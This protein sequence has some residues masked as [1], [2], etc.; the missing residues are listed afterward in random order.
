[1]HGIVPMPLKQGRRD[2]RNRVS[3]D[4]GAVHR[5]DGESLG[6]FE[7]DLKGNLFK[8]CVFRTDSITRFG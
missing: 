4:P 8:I 2:S 3:G 1:M 7:K 6:A 5:R